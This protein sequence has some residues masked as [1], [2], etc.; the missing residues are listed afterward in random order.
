MRL[1]KR[2]VN[3]MKFPRTVPINLWGIALV[4]NHKP[5]PWTIWIFGRFGIHSNNPASP[6]FS[7]FAT[8]IFPIDF[9]FI[10]GSPVSLEGSIVSSSFYEEIRETSHLGES[11]FEWFTCHIGRRINELKR[12]FTAALSRTWMCWIIEFFNLTKF[13]RSDSFFNVSPRAWLFRPT[14][15]YILLVSLELWAPHGEIVKLGA[16]P[17]YTQF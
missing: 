12:H 8:F 5:F 16:S 17:R 13:N 6:P 3:I 1:L 11:Q 14:L 7:T 9:A 2:C 4:L 10:S 15:L